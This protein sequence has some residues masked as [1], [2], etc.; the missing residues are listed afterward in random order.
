MTCLRRATANDVAGMGAVVQDTWDREI[1]PEVCIAQIEDED[2][3]LWVAREQDDVVGFASAFLT[4]DRAGLRRWEVDLL[5]VQRPSQGQG[6]GQ[7][8]IRRVCQDAAGRNVA[9]ARA[10]LRL[11]NVPSQRAFERAGFSTNGQVYHLLLWSPKCID[12]PAAC[13]EGVSLLRVDTLT[14][15]GLWIEGLASLPHAKQRSVARAARATIAREN[16]LNTGAL[17][18][19]DD[20][21]LLAPELQEQATLQGQYCWFVRPGGPT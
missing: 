12:G 3:A 17:I 14:Y 2:S 21:H 4:V 10:A 19:A 16:R 6:L 13:P 5:A 8:L 11:E 7:E 9:L 20:E 18:P 1:L 15:R